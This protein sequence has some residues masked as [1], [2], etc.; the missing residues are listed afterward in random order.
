MAHR[1]PFHLFSH[2]EISVLLLLLLG[3]NFSEE[4]SLDEVKGGYAF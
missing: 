3:C 4:L 1:L 2:I